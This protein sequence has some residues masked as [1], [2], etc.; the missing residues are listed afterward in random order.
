MKLTVKSIRQKKGKEKIVA[1]TAYDYPF[2]RILDGAGVDII[3][4]GDSL[5]MVV[6]GYDST[7][8]VTMREMIHHTKAVSRAVKRALV[9]GDMPFGSYQISTERAFR[10][11]KRFIQEGGAD[12]VKLEGGEPA[13]KTVKTLSRQGIPVMGHLGMTPQTATL[14]GGYKVQGREPKAARKI[15]DDALRL[16]EAGIFSLVLECVPYRL[17]QR[18]TQK[19]S[20]PT[21]GIGA[22]PKTDGQILVLHDLL[23]FEGTVHPRFVRRYAEFEKEAMLAFSRYASDVR[24]G[25]FPSPKES[26][27]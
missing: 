16:E 9:V 15:F 24:S 14:L 27:E 20:C 23:G 10:N 6:L 11:A 2:A 17:A 25:S 18:I 7:L 8:P 13:V 12:A 26:F 1:L 3:L 4:V 21:I 5:G 22:G 19:I